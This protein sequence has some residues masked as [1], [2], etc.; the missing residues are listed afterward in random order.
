MPPS[1]SPQPV[2]AV[3]IPMARLRRVP[4]SVVVTTYDG[5]QLTLNGYRIPNEGMQPVI[6]WPGFYQNGFCFDLIPNGGSLAEYLWRN[7]LDL[8][9]IHSRGTGGSTGRGVFC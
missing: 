9:V 4:L 8:W 6:L 1:N 7:G 2:A 5:S 3:T